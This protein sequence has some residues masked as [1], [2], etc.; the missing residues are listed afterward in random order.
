MLTGLNITQG[1]QYYWSLT[2]KYQDNVIDAAMAL[3]LF[4]LKYSDALVHLMLILNEVSS[5]HF[6]KY[7]NF[8]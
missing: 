2:I 5:L 7:G 3:L 1:W 8:T 6:V 4:T